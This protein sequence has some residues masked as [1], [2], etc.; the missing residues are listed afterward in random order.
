MNSLSNGSLEFEQA[1]PRE[2]GLSARQTAD[3]FP[4]HIVFDRQM[5]VCQTGKS[6]PEVLPKL[7]HG[8]AI[9]EVLELEQTTI[10]FDFPSLLAAAGSQFVLKVREGNLRLRGQ[11]VQLPGEDRLVFLG[12]PLG[13]EPSGPEELRERE[14]AL[15]EATRQLAAETENSKK[16]ALIV[17]SM[18]NAVVV[19]DAMGRVE[20]INAAFPRITGY[21]FEE[22][23]GRTPGSLLWGPETDR[24]TAEFI[25]A[26]IR[27]AR[28]PPGR[29]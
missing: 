9:A 21:S 22:V 16:L 12:S 15:K 20:W 25:E 19:T 14:A 8:T 17:G 27:G 1:A 11:V 26:Q 6:I 2:L 13:A 4:F 5:R 28:A 24:E 29:F 3:L 7:A 18:D 23:R 10:P